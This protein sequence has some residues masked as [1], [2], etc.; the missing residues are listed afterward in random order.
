VRSC[1]IAAPWRYLDGHTFALSIGDRHWLVS[2]LGALGEGVAE[3]AR[4]YP[5]YFQ[6]SDW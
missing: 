4:S 2:V 1:C 5:D 6:S 3:L